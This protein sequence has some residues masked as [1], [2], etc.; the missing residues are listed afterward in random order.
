MTSCPGPHSLL[1]DGTTTART[2]PKDVTGLTRG[3]A[4]VSAGG[5]HTCA[6]TT[7]GGLKC[8]GSNKDGQLGD[9][10]TTDRN[11]PVDVVGL[12]N[13]VVAVSAG[14]GHTCALTSAGGLKCWGSNKDGR[15]GDGTTTDRLTPV[16]IRGLASGVASVSAGSR[17]TCVLTRG[18]GLKCW[19]NN[20]DG[21]L[22]DGTF[23]DRATP[24]NVQELGSGVAAASAGVSH[25]CAVTT[26]GGLKCWGS[27]NSGQLGDGSTGGIPLP[28]APAIPPRIAFT[29]DRDGNLEIYVMKPDGSG[30][31]RLTNN[32]A[33]DGKP[34]WSPDGRRIAFHSNRSGGFEIH[35]MDADGSGQ[36]RLTNS[37][38]FDGNPAWSPD[39]RRIAFET[40]RDGNFEIYVM[41][42]DGSGQTRLTKNTA[43]D[44]GPTWS[45]D[46]RKIAF[47]SN[48]DDADGRNREIYVMNADGSRQ[49][50]LTNAGSVASLIRPAWSPDGR[51][52]AYTAVV[53]TEG[54]SNP[55]IY[56]MD[57]DGSDQDAVAQYGGVEDYAAWSPD[58]SQIL[59][60]ATSSV[61][62]S[63]MEIWTMNAD[64]TGLKK[65]TNN[66]ARDFGP[67][68]SPDPA[69][70]PPV[71]MP[72]VTPVP[73]AAIKKARYILTSGPS[74]WREAEAEA[75]ALGGHLV[76][77]N[78][79]EEQKLLVS[80][81][82]SGNK[83]RRTYWIGLTDRNSEVRFRWVSG[84]P[85]T[86]TNW[87]RGLFGREPN[88]YGS[89][90]DY[91]VMNWHR[92]HGRTGVLGD[93]NDTPM[94]GINAALLGPESYYG[95]IELP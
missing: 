45:P 58:G 79:R 82:L 16:D 27:N 50:R 74:N 56:V 33:F 24:V 2:T 68:W 34:T 78:D 64:G 61:E 80:L 42:A 94:D 54:P 52:I 91:V 15:I 93:W 77:I 44:I 75:V 29:S 43:S 49:T 55:G 25:T 9:G 12:S 13:G 14:S 71:S 31:T 36:T 51:K 19:G 39:G 47:H 88:N 95:I 28:V 37:D 41:N 66:T 35:V 90:E 89:G 65:L 59:F 6:L 38:G 32:D 73:A 53:R 21:Q 81:F 87:N 17:H 4:A 76:T 1:G 92:P 7:A 10:T 30:Q 86:Y 72:T 8:W 20:E 57:A 48:R 5:Y 85:L 60:S 40:D 83:A 3:V 63:K 22:G 46:S 23:A 67:A 26:A 11:T 18:G 84:E 69:S 62:G 70:A